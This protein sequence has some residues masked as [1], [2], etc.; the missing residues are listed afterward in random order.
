MVLN[1]LESKEPV[2]TWFRAINVSRTWIRSAKSKKYEVNNIHRPSSTK[3]KQIARKYSHLDSIVGIRFQYLLSSIP[4]MANP[5]EDINKQIFPDLLS[6]QAFCTQPKSPSS[7][8]LIKLIPS[9]K[10]K[11]IHIFSKFSFNNTY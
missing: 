5:Y 2:F 9:Q 10:W 3:F 1:N 8:K 6:N 7:A 4:V 11:I